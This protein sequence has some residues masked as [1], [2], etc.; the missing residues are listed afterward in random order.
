[1]SKDLNSTSHIKH[2]QN[3]LSIEEHIRTEEVT[4]E[5]EGR[6]EGRGRRSRL[7]KKIYWD[8]KRKSIRSCSHLHEARWAVGYKRGCNV[9]HPRKKT[10]RGVEFSKFIC[11]RIK[12]R[13]EPRVFS[14]FFFLK[15][16]QKEK[17]MPTK[18]CTTQC[19]YAGADATSENLRRCRRSFTGT[20]PDYPPSA[21]RLH[22]GW[23]T[24]CHRR[25][26]LL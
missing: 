6:G 8:Q 17:T 20:L 5:G 14:L 22:R 15:K 10:L 2:I 26:Q 3:A 16:K 12:K 21:G 9:C 4:K 7:S 19:T 18:S 11:S 23:P 25:P 24:H 13:R 1:M